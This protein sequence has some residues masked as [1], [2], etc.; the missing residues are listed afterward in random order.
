MNTYFIWIINR[1][2]ILVFLSIIS[3]V[4]LSAQ[5]PDVVFTFHVRGVYDSKITLLTPGHLG[6]YEQFREIQTIR[7]GETTRIVIPK[8]FLPGEFIVRFD[9]KV[10]ETS[11][12]YPSEKFIFINDQDLELWVNPVY[13]NNL[14]STYFQKNESENTMFAMFSEENTRR[15]EKLGLLQNFLMNYDD[16]KSLFYQEGIKEY[17]QRRQAYNQWLTE[18]HQKDKKLFVSIL[19]QFEYVPQIPWTGTETDRIISLINHYF[20]FIDFNNPLIVKFSDLNKWM[21]NYVNLFG[22]LSTT[23]ALLDSLIPE[24]GRTAI[25][26]AKEGHPLVYGW[27]VDYFFRGFESN[28][29]TSGM[30]I[31]EPYLNDP[32]CLTTK[33]LEINRRL[34]GMKTLLPGTKAPDITLKDPEGNP[35]NLY[36]YTPPCN[37]ILL[38]FWSAGCSHCLETVDNLYPWQQQKENQRKINIVAVGLDETDTDIMKWRDKI[39]AFPAWK[40]FGEPKGVSSKVANDFYVLSTPVMI[41]L[42]SKTKEIVAIPNTLQ[43]LIRAVQ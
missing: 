40:H 20:D 10:K 1:H 39:R 7:N 26:K 38:L 4:D 5:N 3:S 16:Q 41:L 42:N 8:D 24:A 21:D 43:E 29:I 18:Y 28:I 2:I 27:M 34:E 30:K 12:P 37:Y 13:C 11:T 36:S 33:R 32:N 15:K 35:F 14:D 17:E 19:Y 22:Q 31:L 9:Y 25:E 6:Y 23:T